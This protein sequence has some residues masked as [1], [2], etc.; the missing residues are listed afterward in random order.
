MRRFAKLPDHPDSLIGCKVYKVFIFESKCPK[1]GELEAIHLNLL[2]AQH[3]QEATPLR[4]L[5]KRA[6]PN[7]VMAAMGL[8]LVIVFSIEVAI[9]TVERVY[10][11]RLLQR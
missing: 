1:V 4:N 10:L 11:L 9:E 5:K 2:F 8:W 3:P 7:F 6:C